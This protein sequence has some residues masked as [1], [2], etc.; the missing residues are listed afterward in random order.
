MS[1]KINYCS[2]KQSDI[3]IYYFLQF[4]VLF[5]N[6]IGMHIKNTVQVERFLEI[7][8]IDHTV[9]LVSCHCKH[10]CYSYVPLQI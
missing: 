5:F 10:P 9:S 6:N 4:H 1:Y 3:F 8:H 7:I 2:F